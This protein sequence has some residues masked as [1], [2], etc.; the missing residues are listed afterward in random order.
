VRRREIQ[1]I[2]L[3]LVANIYASAPANREHIGLKT[4]ST[5]VI[6]SQNPD[7]SLSLIIYRGIKRRLEGRSERQ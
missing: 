4:T 3:L 2:A 7:V 1:D 5:V 6:W